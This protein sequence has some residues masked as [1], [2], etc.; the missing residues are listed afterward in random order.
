M[1][2]LKDLEWVNWLEIDTWANLGP[3]SKA[4]AISVSV[5]KFIC[6]DQLNEINANQLISIMFA[7]NDTNLDRDL[8]IYWIKN[9][10]AILENDESHISDRDFIIK[11][12]WYIADLFEGLIFLK[13]NH[14]V[15]VA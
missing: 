7:N 4:R 10:N 5:H 2:L 11:N 13:A 15:M 9:V 8:K 12:K 1:K 3:E 14:W 6:S